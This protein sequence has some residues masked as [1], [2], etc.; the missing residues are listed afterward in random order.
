VTRTR[1]TR[2]ASLSLAAIAAVASQTSRA[3]ADP[4]A[5]NRAAAQVLFD[6]GRDLVEKNRFAEA[7]PQFAESQRLDPGIGTLLWLADCYENTGQTASAWSA[8]SQAAEA[9]AD[10]HDAR[11]A[12][13]RERAAKLEASLARLTIVVSPEAA[14][15]TDLQVHCDGVL[16]SKGNWDTPLPLDPGSHTITANAPSH[17][18]WWTTAQVPR[19]ATGTTV[20][21]PGLALDAPA[22]THGLS[23][24]P[25]EPSPS[26][27]APAS[28]GH[29][30]RSQR[31]AAIAIGGGGVVA[32]VL[33]SLF[34][35]KAKSRYD[36]SNAGP[37]LPDNECSPEGIQDRQSASSTAAAA[38]VAMGGG[39]ALLAGAVALYLTAPHDAPANVAV[40]IARSRGSV[41]VAWRW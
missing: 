2:L 25:A 41:D 12:V 39:V 6:R 33:G 5:D 18:L 32:V 7:C 10:Q 26:L 13:A 36:D 3:F 9:A 11:E 21:V 14:A 17:H 20:T 19:E 23:P 29:A 37:C 40:S 22:T 35:I 38:T 16:V 1:A 34:A 8:F 15:L 24:A 30:G 4:S 28:E 27:A 31:I